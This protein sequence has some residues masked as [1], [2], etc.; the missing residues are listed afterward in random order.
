MSADSSGV[1]SSIAEA[2]LAGAA[3]IVV[4]LAEVRAPTAG[5]GMITQLGGLEVAVGSWL[6][7]I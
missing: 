7:S 5:K 1:G 4:G 3:Q 2:L 6:T